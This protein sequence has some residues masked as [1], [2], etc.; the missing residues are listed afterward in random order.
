MDI[1][2]INVLV[3]IYFSCMSPGGAIIRGKT[4]VG[5]SLESILLRILLLFVMISFLPLVLCFG[6]K[7]LH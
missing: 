2:W 5:F 3:S 1:C 6:S 4:A 7:L